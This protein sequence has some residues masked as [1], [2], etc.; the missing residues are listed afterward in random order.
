MENEIVTA[1]KIIRNN[2]SSITTR[3]KE[4][5]ASIHEIYGYLKENNHIIS[6]D[7]YFKTIHDLEERNIIYKGE[8]K[9]NYWVNDEYIDDIDG[10]HDDK[11]KYQ[12]EIKHVAK[13]EVNEDFKDQLLANLYSTVEFLKKELEEKNYVIRSLLQQPKH[14]NSEKVNLNAHVETRSLY[15]DCSDNIMKIIIITFLP[16]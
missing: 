9:N 15:Q 1:I 14:E 7:E 6:E 5:K 13:L 8:G 2:S 4:K 3:P 12:G 11:N 16:S 10:N